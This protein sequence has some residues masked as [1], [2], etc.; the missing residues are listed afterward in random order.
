MKTKLWF[1]GLFLALPL[2]LVIGCSSSGD[3][4]D[5][6]NG[7]DDPPAEKTAKEKL[8]GKWDGVVS[9]S[10]EKFSE[11]FDK[12]PEGE[13]RDK[14]NKKVE[15]LMGSLVEMEFKEDGSFSASIP[16]GGQKQDIAGTWSMTEDKNDTAVLALAFKAGETDMNVS[17]NVTFKKDD[18][19]EAT[20]E[21]YGDEQTKG[22]FFL[23]CYRGK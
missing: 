13:E 8:Q 3:D 20:F 14:L 17:S 12:L 23:D 18:E 9:F 6:P 1:N 22:I 11:V 4:G 16:L 15:D 10:N 5:E 21:P 7:K 2:A 19:V